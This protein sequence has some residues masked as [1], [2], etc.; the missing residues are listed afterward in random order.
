MKDLIR[1]VAKR[2]PLPVAVLL[3]LV[4]GYLVWTDEAARSV[5]LTTM[6]SGAQD[7]D[8][9]QT[10]L[11]G[12]LAWIGQ[13]VHKR[14]DDLTVEMKGLHKT[15]I[16]FDRD[17]RDDIQ[18]TRDMSSTQYTTLSTRIALVEDR[19]DHFDRHRASTCP[20][21]HAGETNRD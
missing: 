20:F 15:L 8:W 4:L 21:H 3:L 16:D 11:I 19:C 1:L 10:A 14:L 18:S 13:Q 17:L 6:V 7:L 2:A 12:V 9:A 5:F